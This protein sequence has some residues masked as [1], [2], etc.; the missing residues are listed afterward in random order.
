M[1]QSLYERIGGQ[2]AV[3][4]AVDIF[5]RKVLSDPLLAPFFEFTDMQR[6]VARQRAFLTMAFGGPNH[7]DGRALRDAHKRFVEQGMAEAHFVAVVEHLLD[8]CAELGVANEDIAEVKAIAL[9][10]H[11]DVLNL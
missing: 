11:D 6:Q 5:Y 8:T 7:Y 2:V 10:V 1:T 4:Q 9:S 3:E